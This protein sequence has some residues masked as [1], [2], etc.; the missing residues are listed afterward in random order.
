[1]KKLA[2]FSAFLGIV[3]CNSQ[4]QMKPLTGT[5][6]IF[7]SK[8]GATETVAKII[9]DSLKNGNITIINLGNEKAPDIS[10]CSRVIIGGS[11]HMGKIQSKIRKYCNQNLEALKNKELGL[12]L[13]CMSEGN[14]G[15]QQFNNAYPEQLRQKAKS[16]L[17]AGYELHFDK[18]NFF[19]KFIMKKITGGSTNVS[20]LNYNEINRFVNEMKK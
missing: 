10:Q 2:I 18:M 1:M 4:S 15:L 6:I 8:H 14:E 5:A 17:M 7:M 20:R 11:I 16:T 19:E 3:A 9:R 13:C 12:F